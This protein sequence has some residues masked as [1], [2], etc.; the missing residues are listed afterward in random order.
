VNSRTSFEGLARWWI[1]GLA[2]LGA[3]SV[4]H[5]VGLVIAADAEPG[6][7]LA[8]ARH[9]DTAQKFRGLEARRAA[10][11]F[12]ERLPDHRLTVCIGV[13]LR[14][15]AEVEALGVAG[16]AVSI[17]GITVSVAGVS[18]AGVTVTGVTVTGVTV[19][20]VTVTG[21]SIAVALHPFGAGL[22]GVARL[23]GPLGGVILAVVAASDS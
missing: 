12:F 8:A 19:T 20:G 18:V 21:I 10:A 13:A 22:R 17:A 7:G 6:L 16:V 23:A 15:L 3:A 5:E 9:G 11:S 2:V 4:G 14:L 1:A